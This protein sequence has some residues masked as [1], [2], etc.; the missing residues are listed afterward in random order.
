MA[1]GGGVRGVPQLSPSHPALVMWRMA[2]AS[3]VRELERQR[4]GQARQQV[5]APREH[6]HGHVQLLW[7]LDLPGDRA[8][9]V[10]MGVDAVQVGRDRAGHRGGDQRWHAPRATSNVAQPHVARG[11][12]LACRAAARAMLCTLCA[13]PCCAVLCALCALCTL[14][15]RVLVGG[16]RR[17]VPCALSARVPSAASR[18]PLSATVRHLACTQACGRTTRTSW[19]RSP[20]IPISAASSTS[21]A[22]PSSRPLSGTRTTSHKSTATPSTSA[23]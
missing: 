12:R 14:C 21:C 3:R 7:P 1:S 9:V 17:L 5:H 2:A 19:L 13:L 6:H 22:S 16:G 15:V 20:S 10:P 18:A 23:P 11:R 4:V 8:H